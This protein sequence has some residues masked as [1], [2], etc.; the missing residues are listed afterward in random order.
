MQRREQGLFSKSN[1]RQGDP[2]SEPCPVRR[3]AAFGTYSGREG[4]ASFLIL[5]YDL[6]VPGGGAV[7]LR[8][9]QCVVC[10]ASQDHRRVFLKV[11]SSRRSEHGTWAGGDDDVCMCMPHHGQRPPSFRVKCVSS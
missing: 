2:L 8:V 9:G 4:K 3:V 10:C 6:L 7:P 5:V 11:G 1:A